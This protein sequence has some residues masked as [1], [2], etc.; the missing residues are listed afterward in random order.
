[1]EGETK[2]IESR[3][4]PKNSLKKIALLPWGDIF[5]EDFLDRLGVSFETFRDEFRGSWMFGWID[6]LRR[7]GV[8]P[9]TFWFSARTPSPLR[10]THKPTGS[11]MCVLPIAPSYRMI[12][13]RMVRPYAATVDEMFGPVRGARRVLFSLLKQVAPY[14]STPPLRLAREIR[15][16]GCQ[17]ILCQQYDT[18]RFDVCAVLGK[19]LRLPVFASY[20]GGGDLALPP[21]E[22]FV[23]PK[24]LR[25]CAGLVIP[26]YSEAQRVRM[27]YRTPLSK[28]ARIF[29]PLHLS[30]KT[31]VNR[32]A[33]RELL[34][35]PPGA[36]VAV[37][38]GRV[39]IKQKGLDI[40]LEAWERVCARWPGQDPRL[41]LMG[42]GPDAT[43]LRSRIAAAPS[44]NII[45]NDEFVHDAEMIQRCLSSAD[46][47]VFPSRWE[48]FPVSPIEA[49]ACGLPVVA[50]DAS[51]IPEIFERG[52]EHGGIVI[53]GCDAERLAE[54]LGRVLGD[55]DLA[56]KLG[57]R[58]RERA[59]YFSVEKVGEQLRSFFS[60]P[61]SK[62][63][64]ALLYSDNDFNELHSLAQSPLRLAALHPA[65]AP[66]RT[67]FNV[68]PGGQAAMGISTQNATRGTLVVMGSE[69]LTTM[70][71]SPSYLT[72][73]VPLKLLRKPGNYL[74]Y[75]TDAYRESN[76]LE[77]QVI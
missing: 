56:R 69:F 31:P 12:R 36:R 41:L 6:A 33:Q 2:Q 38:H 23:R 24:A 57:A 51:G 54:G 62:E 49:M 15:R 22:R 73:L 18:P 65:E 9:T 53:P 48:G 26:S 66:A 8:E 50:S 1:M 13:R 37:W 68:Q 21:M 17:A 4:M 35:I 55:I 10:F 30:V 60:D 16:E 76:R 64:R 70:Y 61:G 28:M 43:E 29:N 58:G 45:W 47:Y 20:Q 19:L 32:L 39:E 67:V 59:R 25:A 34:G 14:L 44:K 3:L 42:T 74:V 40:L 75:L 46:V 72:V 77:F 71:V 63:S 52:E 5:D 11:K 27:R 7:A